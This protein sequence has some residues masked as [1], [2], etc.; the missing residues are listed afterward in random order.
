MKAS[1]IF[2]TRVL[3]ALLAWA[4]II[5]V[6]TLIASVYGMNFRHMPELMLR[7][8]Y[9]AALVLMLSTAIGLYAYFRRV[10][11]L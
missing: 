6:P 3:G 7:Y 10:R 2:P 5:T 4:A 1:G 11:W 9:P 8:G